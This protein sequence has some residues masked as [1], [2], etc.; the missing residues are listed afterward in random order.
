MF[1][2][3]QEVCPPSHPM[4]IYIY[5]YILD[6]R[7]GAKAPHLA[8]VSSLSAR[9]G[10][11]RKLSTTI[12]S[13]LSTTCSTA[14]P[15]N[16]NFVDNFEAEAPHLARVSARGAWP[17]APRSFRTSISS[18]FSRIWSSAKLP[19]L[20]FVDNFEELEH[21]EASGPWFRRQFR[22][23]RRQ[24]EEKTLKNPKIAKAPPYPHICRYV[25]IYVFTWINIF[26]NIYK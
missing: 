1:G 15:P 24:R 4:Y 19:N 6:A 20:D 17:G 22:R 18:T 12:S 10:A 9:P 8:R 2:Y 25:Y 14:E 26:D 21:R 23:F 16:S 7:W 13:T 11:P 3:A 5:I